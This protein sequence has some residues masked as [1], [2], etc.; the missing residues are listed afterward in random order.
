MPMGRWGCR[1]TRREVMRLNPSRPSGEHLDQSV[2]VLLT[3]EEGF[4]E[5][6]FVLAVS[7]HILDGKPGGPE[8]RDSVVTQ[9]AAVSCAGAHRWDRRYAWPHL[10]SYLLDGLHDAWA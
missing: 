4:H 2:Q 5:N 3:I 10:A 1:I 9:I 8:G 7:A 6:A